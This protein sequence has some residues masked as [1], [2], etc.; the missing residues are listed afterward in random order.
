MPKE[1]LELKQAL[2]N[3]REKLAYY[4]GEI[5]L[6]SSPKKKFELQKRIEE[7]GERIKKIKVRLKVDITQQAIDL[8]EDEA[9]AQRWLSTPKDALEGKTPLEALKTDKGSKEVEELLYRAEYGIFG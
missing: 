7:C 8:F 3:W 9:E 4:E 5:S 1:K 6:T 2:S